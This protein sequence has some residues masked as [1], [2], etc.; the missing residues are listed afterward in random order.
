M[1]GEVGDAVQCSSGELLTG[2]LSFMRREC[3]KG[4]RGGGESR[5]HLFLSLSNFLPYNIATSCLTAVE[6]FCITT[7]FSLKT[8]DRGACYHFKINM[9]EM[10][11]TT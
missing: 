11:S 8:K 2:D 3:R 7:P 5:N 6:I 9:F 4:V 10:H 1:M